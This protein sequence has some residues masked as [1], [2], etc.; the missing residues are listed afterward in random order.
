[1]EKFHL[2]HYEDNA[3]FLYFAVKKYICCCQVKI[4][5]HQKKMN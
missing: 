4:Y 3:L 5:A 1:M 2:F